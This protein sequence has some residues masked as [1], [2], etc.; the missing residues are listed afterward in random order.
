MRQVEELI[1]DLRTGEET[2]NETVEH[3]RTNPIFSF[4][5]RFLMIEELGSPV[6][7]LQS[8]YGT[9]QMTEIGKL[10]LSE[11]MHIFPVFTETFEEFRSRLVVLLQEFSPEFSANRLS[12]IQARFD[13]LRS[14][15]AAL[16]PTHLMLERH[17][18]SMVAVK[19]RPMLFEVTEDQKPY[20]KLASLRDEYYKTPSTTTLREYLSLAE[21]TLAQELE[22]IETSQF[23]ASPDQN[24]HVLA[25]LHACTVE[26]EVM[27]LVEALG[28]SASLKARSA[29]V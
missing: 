4:T 24:K 23:R 14:S 2:Y 10:P 13:A 15:I 19:V 29:H 21:V 28:D 20:L 16:T 3:E 11:L 27:S 18:E 17:F 25:R 8:L 5:K 6:D 26:L 7:K 22:A 12:M 1:R 9:C